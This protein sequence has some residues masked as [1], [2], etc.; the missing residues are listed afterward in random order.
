M[1]NIDYVDN[2]SDWETPLMKS[3]NPSDTYGISNN[4]DRNNR[5]SNDRQGK[6][7]VALVSS[8]QVFNGLACLLVASL[9]ILLLE[10]RQ[11]GVAHR[12][13]KR[14]YNIMF[15]SAA[16]MSLHETPV[17]GN[18]YSPIPAPFL[19]HPKARFSS[20]EHQIPTSEPTVLVGEHSY[21][22]S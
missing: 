11:P 4:K 8:K 6:N 12:T 17:S 10:L 21:I 16:Q 13:V 15:L 19:K 2:E 18:H 20:G 22:D 9:C 5:G 14:M 3:Q 1:S 7:N